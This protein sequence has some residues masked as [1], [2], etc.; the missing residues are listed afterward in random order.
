VS[1]ESAVP[2]DLNTYD[3]FNEFKKTKAKDALKLFIPVNTRKWFRNKALLKHFDY[4]PMEK[5]IKMELYARYADEIAQLQ[6]ILGRDL[7]HWGKE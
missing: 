4:P 6:K 5:E 7:S 3:L 2:R 1:N